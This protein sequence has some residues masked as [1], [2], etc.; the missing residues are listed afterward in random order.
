MLAATHKFGTNILLN[1]PYYREYIS[2]SSGNA[3]IYCIFSLTLSFLTLSLLLLEKSFQYLLHGGERAHRVVPM[4][5][6]AFQEMEWNFSDIRTSQA[7]YFY[8]SVCG[9]YYYKNHYNL[10]NSNKIMLDLHL[11]LFSM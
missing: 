1:T 5:S 11:V 4:G 7:R 8:K 10:K 9:V 6:A 3:I 2:Y